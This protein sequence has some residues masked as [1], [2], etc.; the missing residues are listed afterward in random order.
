MVLKYLKC[1]KIGLKYTQNKLSKLKVLLKL[2]GLHKKFFI[3]N[4]ELFEK[5]FLKKNEELLLFPN[6]DNVNDLLIA[7][8]IL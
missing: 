2:S 5:H 8:I 7:A 1:C 3:Q 4:S 6:H